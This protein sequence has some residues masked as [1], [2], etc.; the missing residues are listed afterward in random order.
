MTGKLLSSEMG[1]LTISPYLLGTGW[2]IFC[3]AKQKS[4]KLELG[5]GWNL[6][7]M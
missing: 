3:L 6:Q 5:M 2:C 7:P 1:Q 4:H